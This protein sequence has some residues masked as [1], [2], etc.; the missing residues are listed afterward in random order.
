M[1]ICDY[2]RRFIRPTANIPVVTMAK[3]LAC[4]SLIAFAATLQTGFAQTA[5]T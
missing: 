1:R 2:G 3:T 4:T 5:D